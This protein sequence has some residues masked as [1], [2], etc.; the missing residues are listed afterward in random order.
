MK[1][2]Y[3]YAS[4]SL[5]IPTWYSY[6]RASDLWS[7]VR[8]GT[9][10]DVTSVY[11]E[12]NL[13]GTWHIDNY[14]DGF[15]IE[16]LSINKDEAAVKYSAIVFA[17]RGIMS[18]ADKPLL[19]EGEGVFAVQNGC[20]RIQMDLPEGVHC[21]NENTAQLNV[22]IHRQLGLDYGRIDGDLLY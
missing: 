12:K 18:P 11:N 4:E 20:I 17:R 1:I 8:K 21:Q 7:L 9:P 2:E 16:I 10:S 3:N 13:R 6:N 14:D 22:Y 19:L 5:S 15:D